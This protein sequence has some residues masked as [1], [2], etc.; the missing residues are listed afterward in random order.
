MDSEH[1]IDILRRNISIGWKTRGRL[2]K[3]LQIL[4]ELSRQLS[5]S[6][7]PPQYRHLYQ[8]CFITPTSSYPLIVLFLSDG[9]L[10][11]IHKI[12]HQDVVAYK[13]F[14]RHWPRK[15]RFGHYQYCSL[16]ITNL[17]VEQR[18]RKI[19]FLHKILLHKNIEYEYKQ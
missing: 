6:H 17:K 8:Q 7:M 12:I 10:K 2:E 9:K 16:E 14:N 15:L 19:Q 1:T 4:R 3:L 5:T 13:R 18:L 11:I